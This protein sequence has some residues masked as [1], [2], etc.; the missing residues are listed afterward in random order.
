MAAVTNQALDPSPSTNPSP[1]PP[2]TS[3]QQGS[4]DELRAALLAAEATAAA[5]TAAASPGPG[6]RFYSSAEMD[7]VELSCFLGQREWSVADAA[8]QIGVA[9]AWR[10]ALGEVSFARQRHSRW[11][12]NDHDSVTRRGQPTRANPTSRRAC[13]LPAFSFQVSIR[14]VAPF[15]RAPAADRSSPDGCIVLLEVL[16]ARPPN[17]CQA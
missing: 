5:T 2:L 6:D 8:A 13:A 3:E 9:K 7:D 12:T 11:Q 1:R 4:V 17:G 14:D 16:T 15:L 10:N